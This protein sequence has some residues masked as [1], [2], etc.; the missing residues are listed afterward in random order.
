MLRD[1]VSRVVAIVVAWAMAG[2]LMAVYDELVRQSLGI[3]V[4]GY[5]FGRAV[6]LKTL[7]TTFGAILAATLVVFVF[8]TRLRGS[9]FSVAVVVQGT[10]FAV[11]AIGVMWLMGRFSP[12][13]VSRSPVAGVSGVSTYAMLKGVAFALGLSGLTSFALEVNDRIGRGAFL[14]FVLG[15]YHRART[16]RRCFMFLDLKGSTA[17]AVELGH[18]RFFEFL[19]AFFADVTDAIVETR[20]EIYQYVGDEVVVSWPEAVGL[21]RA[22]CVRCFLLIEKTIA[23]HAERYRER[24]GVV[25]RFRAAFH[26]GDVTTGEVGVLKRDQ[27]FTGET[28]NTTARIEEKCKALKLDALVSGEL[29]QALPESGDFTLR[30]VENAELRGTNSRTPLYLVEER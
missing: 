5:S 11:I 10:A 6:A 3:E 25:P 21:E 7:G 16:E 22:N 17:L 15:R 28:L 13:V 2:L 29:S 9:R 14:E 20:G 23:Q 27:V 12:V 4:P 1:K 18:V 30:L 19:N 8:K 24:F 26:V